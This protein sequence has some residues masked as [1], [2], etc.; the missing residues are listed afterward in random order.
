MLSKSLL[1][2]NKKPLFLSIYNPNDYIPKTSLYALFF[3]QNQ[4]QFPKKLFQSIVTSYFGGVVFG[5]MMLGLTLINSVGLGGMDFLGDSTEQNYKFQST[6]EFFDNCKYQL[7][8]LHHNG[9]F[10]IKYTLFMGLVNAA[11]IYV[12]YSSYLIHLYI[13]FQF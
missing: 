5:G 9:T 10:V 6:Q 11:S 1:N 13:S 7:R 2:K 8:S 3:N 12:S 4:R